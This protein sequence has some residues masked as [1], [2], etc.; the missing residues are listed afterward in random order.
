MRVLDVRLEEA[1]QLVKQQR[2]TASLLQAEQPKPGQEPRRWRRAPVLR[3]LD[4][5]I[6][7]CVSPT[8]RAH[9]LRGDEVVALDAFRSMVLTLLVQPDIERDAE[10]IHSL[11]QHT[12]TLMPLP[13][14]EPRRD[15]GHG[16][17]TSRAQRGDSAWPR[18]SGSASRPRP[19]AAPWR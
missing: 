5:E 10:A 15:S 8:T 17:G 7:L 12:A 18:H 13:S 4:R 3:A 9:V 14:F 6:V 19:A 1:G 16:G 11:V 2:L